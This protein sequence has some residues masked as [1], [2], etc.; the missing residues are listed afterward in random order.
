MNTMGKF[1]QRFVT[2]SL[3]LFE[4]CLIKQKSFE[5]GSI[6][7]AKGGVMFVGDWSRV[8]PKNAMKLLREIETGQVTSEGMQQS[9]P[10]KCAVWGFWSGSKKMKKDISS[11]NQF[12]GVFGVP[13]IIDNESDEEIIERLLN[14][15]QK[16]DDD[17]EISDNDL[18]MYLNYASKLNVEISDESE[19]TLNE[20]FSAIRIIR[21]GKFCEI[22]L[23]YN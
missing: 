21:P 11:L 18:R 14:T 5:A 15:T 8:Q 13:T 10:L 23:K 2:S 22:K 7:M 20:Y 12:I 4:G 9:L 16:C 1:A 6:L 3:P 17:L 19:L